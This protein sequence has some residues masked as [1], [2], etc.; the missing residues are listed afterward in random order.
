MAPRIDT[1]YTAN[2]HTSRDGLAIAAIVAHGTGGYDN[3]AGRR[4]LQRG[5]EL[6]DGSDRKVSIHC[7]IS[8]NGTIYRMVPDAYGANHAGAASAVLKTGGKIYRAGKINQ[9]TLGFELANIQDGIDPYPEPQ[10]NAMGWQV[11]EWRRL[12]GPLPLYRHAEI[13]PTRRSDPVRLSVAAMEARVPSISPPTDDDLTFVSAPRISLDVFA[14]VLV[15][16]ASPAASDAHD[17]YTIPLQYG[18]DPAVALA[19]FEHESKYGKVGICKEFNTKNWGNVRT[20]YDPTLSIGSTD[21]PFA[22]YATWHDGLDDWCKRILYRYI[23][24]WHLDTV[25]KALPKYAPKKDKNNPEAYGNAVIANVK[26]WSAL[27][28]PLVPSLPRLSL[29]RVS[30]K[31]GARVFAKSHTAATKVRLVKHGVEVAGIIV[32]GQ[33]Y[34]GVKS[35]L[36]LADDSGYIWRGSLQEVT[37]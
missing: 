36:H 27:I 17:L 6:P 9:V 5:G 18:I 3:D 32:E 4:Y 24:I 1:T 13:D 35:W 29:Y 20:P 16:S 22:K 10:L 2:W 33:L 37:L 30:G 21:H 7:Y 25:R 28:L 15:E 8:K 14:R 12:Y 26:K 11:A 23:G 31:G 34:R 19:F